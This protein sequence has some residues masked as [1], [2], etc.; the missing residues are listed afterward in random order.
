MIAYRMATL[1]VATYYGL[2]EHIG[3]IAPGRYADILFLQSLEQ[4]H[5]V[6]VMAEGKI[7]KS[8]KEDVEPCSMKQ[9]DWNEYGL[10]YQKPSHQREITT[11]D[12][13][14]P[15]EEGKPFPVMHLINDV[16]TVESSQTFP[17]NVEG[18][19]QVEQE[20]LLYVAL[21]HREGSWITRGV[22][23]GFATSL[24]GL[25]TTYTL[26]MD[27]L[28]I[29]KDFDSMLQAYH[30]VREHGGIAIVEDQQ[31]SAHLQ[32]PIGGGMSD[33]PMQ[34]LIATST[35]FRQMLQDRGFAHGDPY[36]CLLFLTSTHLPKLRLTEDGIVSIKDQKV[37]VPSQ[38][39]KT[40]QQ[41]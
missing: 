11:T 22:L 28:V 16:I 2:D 10:G 38:S 6:Q 31:V 36:Y 41:S 27:Y 13:H 37:V 21:I 29:G 35:E 39:L 9:L 14:I 30:H 23:G 25:A 34:E 19:L 12:F 3:L 7:V 1:N 17:L 40:D 5:P 18:K 33:L 26:S 24:S 8:H 15:W 20:G 32:L 4:P